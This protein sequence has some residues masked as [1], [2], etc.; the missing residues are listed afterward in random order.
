MIALIVMGSLLGSHVGGSLQFVGAG[1]GKRFLW[2]LLSVFVVILAVALVQRIFVRI[3]PEPARM[4][5]DYAAWAIT[6]V[7][8][9]FMAAYFS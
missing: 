5:V 3:L 9:A 2:S 4:V 7:A 8:V 1:W 6:F